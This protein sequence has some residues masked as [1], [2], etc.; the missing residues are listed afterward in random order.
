MDF[1]NS[2]EIF[3][4]W[5]LKNRER[6]NARRVDIVGSRHFAACDKAQ[7]DILYFVIHR[8]SL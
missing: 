2:E 8:I 7:N 4:R 1:D 3:L 6:K 5:E